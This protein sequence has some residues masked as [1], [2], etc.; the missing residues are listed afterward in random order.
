MTDPSFTVFTAIVPA[1]RQEA[2]EEALGATGFTAWS[3]ASRL[4]G[5]HDLTLYGEGDQ[6]GLP[7]AVAAALTGLGLAAAAAGG[8]TAEELVRGYLPDQPCELCPEVWID[9]LGTLADQPG[10]TRLRLAP[11]L[12]FGDGHHPSTRMAAGL[13][14]GLPLEGAAVLDLGCGTGVLG[15][16]ALL[17]GAAAGDFTD[18]DPAAL[19][20]TRVALAAHGCQGRVFPADLLDGVGGPYRLVI[21][22]LYADLVLMALADPRLA[23]V[24]PQGWLVLSGIHA[25][26]RAAVRAALAAAGFTVDAEREEAWWCAFLASR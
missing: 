17:R 18:I 25:R 4:D 7:P 1:E 6:A 13:I 21:A 11:S 10:R 22:N 2:L 16:L 3:L 8:G 12:A 14:V 20:A 5:G 15:L 23:V 19:A 24:L 9:P 26:H